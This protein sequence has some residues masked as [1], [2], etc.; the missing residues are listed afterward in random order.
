MGDTLARVLEAAGYDVTLEYY[1]NDA[2]RQITLLGEA[3]QIR[4]R[5]LLGEDI[6]LGEDHYRGEYIVDIANELKQ[7]YGNTLLQQPVDI[8]R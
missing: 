5:Q 8:F 7:E 6:K 4:Y 2:G 1:Y 3:V